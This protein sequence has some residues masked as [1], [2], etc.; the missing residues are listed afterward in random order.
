MADEDAKLAELAARQYGLA[1][2]AQLRAAGLSRH[3][4]ATRVARHWLQ[5]V[6]RC[7]YA[8]GHPPLTWRAR[9]LAAVLACG[10]G[11]ALSHRAAGALWE[12][13]PEPL[14]PV[15]VTV[16]TTHGRRPRPGIVLHRSMALRAGDIRHRHG[17]PVTSPARTVVDLASVL[18]RRR[19]ERVIDACERLGLCDLDALEAIVEAQPTRPGAGA[20]A[21]VLREHRIGST[22]TRS[23][24]EELFLKLCREHGLP[25]PEVNA[26][27]LGLKVD[28]LWADAR[29]IVEVDGRQSHDTHL[30][31]QED[32]DR[33]SRLTVAGYRP[34]RFT[35]RDVMKRPA[36]VAGRVRDTIRLVLGSG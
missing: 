1:T 5:P 9:W 23:E 28:F 15:E 13:G 26:R 4:I 20:V 11:A 6:H 30:A 36:V 12:I 18:P 34:L 33:D 16:P 8:V 2:T 7:V 35:Y 17:I 29:V 31:Y 27:V 22:L 25:Q 21:A 24:L 3:E 19:L 14:G 32:R 10:N